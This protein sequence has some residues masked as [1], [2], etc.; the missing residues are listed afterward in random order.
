MAVLVHGWWVPPG[1]DLFC[2]NFPFQHVE[3]GTAQ[4]TSSSESVLP[5]VVLTGLSAWPTATGRLRTAA[6]CLV[7][8]WEVLIVWKSHA[9]QPSCHLLV[10]GQWV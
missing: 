9:R 1:K 5:R 8:G 4:T 6:V 3:V 7:P 10:S 2:L